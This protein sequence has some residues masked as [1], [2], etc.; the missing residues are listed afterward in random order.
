MMAQ[1]DRNLGEFE[2]LIIL[3]ILRKDNDSYGAEISATIENFAGRDTNFGALYTTL[4][5][6][7]KKGLVTSKI[8]EA[9]AVRGGRAKKYFQVTASGQSA[10]KRS[11]DTILTMSKGLDMLNEK[12]LGAC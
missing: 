2:Q 7:E 3:A 5:R 11:V 4:S 1:Q 6:L 10:V 12:S 8:G 9:T